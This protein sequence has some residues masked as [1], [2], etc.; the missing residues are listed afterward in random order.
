MADRSAPVWADGLTGTRQRERLPA[1]SPGFSLFDATENPLSRSCHDV[2]ESS[3][4]V[5]R[6][7][8]PTI[9]RSFEEFFEAEHVRL[10]RALYLLTGSTA[11]ADELSQE[12]FVR[13]YERWDR[14]RDM[15]SPEG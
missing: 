3:M 12:A 15:T 14:V 4:V 11:E 8:S 6:G 7:G 5:L 9:A 10:G 2:L 13:V 1:Y